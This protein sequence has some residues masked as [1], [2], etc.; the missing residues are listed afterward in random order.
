MAGDPGTDAPT[1]A[2]HL[3]TLALA[4]AGAGVLSLAGVAAAPISGALIACAG[5]ALCNVRQHVAA[6][7]RDLSFAV[8][9]VTVGATVDAQ[10]IAQLPQWP[11]SL[12]VLAVAMTVLVVVLSQYFTR[13]HGFDRLTALLCAFPGA[14]SVVVALSET[15]DVDRRRIAVMQSVRVVSL[16]LVVPLAVTVG[17]GDP[18]SAGVSKAPLAARD[19]IVI[20]VLALAGYAAARRLSIPAAAFTGPMIV[21]AVAFGSGAVAG[22]LPGAVVVAAFVV[23]GAV[24][25]ARFNGVGPAYLLQTLKPALGGLFIALLIT[26]AAAWPVAEGLGLPFVQVWL[27]MAPGGFDAM[28]ALAIALDTDPA[29]VAGHQFAR[30]MALYAVLPFLAR[31]WT[32]TGA[33]D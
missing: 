27:A 11:V 1:K 23:M 28:A 5:A 31:R 19:L 18:V 6:P 10:T 33:N 8:I 15:M 29:F 9:G 3:R 7:L 16:L 21:T 30:L 20:A 4:G 12:T 22:A 25:G 32:G 26:V 2:V 13:A 17:L 14:L 24:I